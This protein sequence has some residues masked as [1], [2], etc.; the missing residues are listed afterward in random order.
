[1][2]ILEAIWHLVHTP[3]II[4]SIIIKEENTDSNGRIYADVKS[5]VHGFC[6]VTDKCL[7]HK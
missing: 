7:E 3:V 4:T 2:A 1:M 5:V 6:K